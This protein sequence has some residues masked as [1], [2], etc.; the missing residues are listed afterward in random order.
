MSKCPGSGARTKGMSDVLMLG[1]KTPCSQLALLS[2]LALAQD[3][4]LLAHARYLVEDAL[5]SCDAIH[6]LT[7]MAV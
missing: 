2:L 6:L 4:P 1:R 7:R 3:V 5:I